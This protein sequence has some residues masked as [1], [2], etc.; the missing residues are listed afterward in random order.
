[1]MSPRN[2]E[3]DLQAR[4]RKIEHILDSAIEVMAVKGIGTVSMQD[5]AKAANISVG[6]LYHYFK[7]KD[8]VFEQLL[9]RGQSEYGRY[10]TSI[11][12]GKNSAVDKL[13]TICSN[14]LS[15]KNHWAYTI[16]IHT[17]R[18]SETS[19][20]ALREQVTSWFTRNLNPVSQIM[21]QG[22]DEGTIKVGNPQQLAFYFVSLIQGLT[23][24]RPPGAEVP[25]DINEADLIGLFRKE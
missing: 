6:N 16:L 25:V 13:Y 22:Q 18:T 23:L 4:E 12:N 15:M 5:I 21:K 7:S 3:R 1:M 11:A 24:Q 8:E 10:V 2:I 9:L 20:K 17:A 19:S 14:W